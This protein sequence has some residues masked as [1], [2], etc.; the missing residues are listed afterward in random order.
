VL[1][2]L[3]LLLTLQTSQKGC[4]QLGLRQEKRLQRGIVS[5]LCPDRRHCNGAL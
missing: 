3:L 1:L 2:L 4:A 5:G